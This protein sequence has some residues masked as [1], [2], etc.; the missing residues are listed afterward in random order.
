MKKKYSIHLLLSIGIFLALV[1]WCIG[2]SINYKKKFDANVDSY[3]EFEILCKKDNTS[4]DRNNCEMILESGKPVIPDTITVFFQ[5]LI[6]TSLSA[7]Q[8]LAPII[9]FVL[10]GYTF[11]REYNTGFYKN[12]LMRM[13]Y[14][15]YLKK[16]L[17]RAYKN[18]WI[19][20]A[21]ILVLFVCSYLISGHFSIDKTLS[22]WPEYYIPVKLEFITNFK[23]FIFI[24]IINIIFNTFF[25]IHL[26]LIPIRRNYNFI[27]NILSSYLIFIFC[28]I[29]L[30]VLVGVVICEKILHLSNFSN[31]FSLFN[32]WAYVDIPN[33]YLYTLYCF[34]LDI[35]SFIALYIIY[36]KK[37]EVII[38]SEK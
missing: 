16:V 18:L 7:I 11:Y 33:I 9:I 22:Y 28:D 8:L 12:Q 5:L 24:F 13:S 20:P 34:L 30:E 17:L 4:M 21:W 6:N 23:T 37:E 1:L 26:A 32:F 38:D 29:F 31:L 2:C 27:V 10:A 14:K 36:H 3:N 19:F 25:Y 35:I 15:S